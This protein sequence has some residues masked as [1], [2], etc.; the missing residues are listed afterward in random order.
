MGINNSGINF[1]N[2]LFMRVSILEKIDHLRLL[3][4]SLIFQLTWETP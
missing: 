2:N 4:V 1:L 3:V